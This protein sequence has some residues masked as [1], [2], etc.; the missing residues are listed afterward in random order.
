MKVACETGRVSLETQDVRATAHELYSRYGM[1]IE[2]RDAA[3]DHRNDCPMG[4]L[5]SVFWCLVIKE[6]GDLR[7]LFGI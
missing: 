3:T 1:Y 4:S 2:V 6:L 7:E 5:E